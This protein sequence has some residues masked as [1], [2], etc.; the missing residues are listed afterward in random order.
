MEW[1]TLQS[2]LRVPL[3]VGHAPHMV[4]AA[5]AED[6]TRNARR[7]WQRFAVLPCDDLAVLYGCYRVRQVL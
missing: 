3:N 5:R 4:H 1:L 6:E 7:E 2:E